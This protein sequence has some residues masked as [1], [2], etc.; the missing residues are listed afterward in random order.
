MDSQQQPAAQKKPGC[1]AFRLAGAKITFA[2]RCFALIEDL[3]LRLAEGGHCEF[4]ASE[5]KTVSSMNHEI[6]TPLNGIAGHDRLAR[7]C[8]IHSSA[9]T[10]QSEK[11]SSRNLRADQD[12]LGAKSRPDWLKPNRCL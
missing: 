4:K 3:E 5:N 1:L 10:C 8:S 11:K 6:R 9:P 2:C 7:L 12:V